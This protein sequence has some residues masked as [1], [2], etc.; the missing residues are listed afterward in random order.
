MTNMEAAGI[1][2]AS[3]SRSTK[4]STYLAG[5][6][7]F[8]SEVS[9]RRDTGEAIFVGIRSQPTKQELQPILLNGAIPGP[10]GKNLDDVTAITQPGQT[11]RLRL[12]ESPGFLGGRLATSVCSFSFLA[13][14]EPFSP[15]FS[16]VGEMNSLQGIYPW[17]FLF[18][19]STIFLVVNPLLVWSVAACMREVMKE[20][21]V[22]QAL[23]EVAKL[24][25]PSKR[26]R[27][28][29]HELI[30]Y[31]THPALQDDRVDYPRYRPLGLPI[32]SG[33]VEAQCKA[34]VPARCKQ[35]GM[36]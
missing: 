29:K 17:S 5:C 15:P 3:S 9:N 32:G 2:P 16:M 23:E 34:L 18:N 31:L 1:E 7:N 22:E 27:R 13:Q 14:V 8:A 10:A 20:G 33:E 19:N 26:R 6:L 12:F 35:S 36:R 11:F 25:A 28:A 24:A 21:K 4:A 30:T